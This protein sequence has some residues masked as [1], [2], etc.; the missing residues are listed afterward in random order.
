MRN[1]C[2][3]RITHLVTWRA[4]RPRGILESNGQMVMSIY[5]TTGS[6]SYDMAHGFAQA[7]LTRVS[8]ELGA[9]DADKAKHAAFVATTLILTTSLLVSFMIYSFRAEWLQASEYMVVLL[10]WSPEYF[11]SWNGQLAGGKCDCYGVHWRS[12]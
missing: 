8:H 12:G 6:L 10:V 7:A 5:Q 11:W 4:Y 3:A 1:I 2:S 9:G